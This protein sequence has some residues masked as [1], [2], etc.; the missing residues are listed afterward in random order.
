MKRT[1]AL[2]CVIGIGLLLAVPAAAQDAETREAA[3]E[4]SA[5][6][7]P[8]VLLETTMGEITV[9]LF[10][11]K[12]PASVENFLRYMD[13]KF[14]DG[15]IFHRVIESFVI[16]GGGWTREMVRKE[17]HEPIVNEASNGLSNTRGTLAMART[18]DV[19]SATSQFFIN[20]VDNEFL[21]H[22]TKT[23]QGYGYC[24]FGKVI[25]GMDVVD[26]IAAVKTGNAGRM[27]NV[28]VKPVVIKSV[29]RAKATS[30]PAD[31]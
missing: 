23:R 25:D 10:A 1:I 12:A 16:Q 5:A 13:E 9:E 17:T 3:V 14:Y 20:L 18:S 27:Q 7:N 8:V 15:T 2:A 30:K 22:K 31:G 6:E 4:E 11:D 24:V 26:K 19:N 21:N 29:R 28:P